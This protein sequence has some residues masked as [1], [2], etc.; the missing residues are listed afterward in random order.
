MTSVFSALFSHAAAPSP[1]LDHAPVREELFGI[2]RL[3]QH[4]YTLAAAQP[5][6]SKPPAV[7]SL[8]RRLNDNAKVL[9]AAYRASAAELANGRGV[10]P[11]AEWLLDNYHLVEEQIREI[12]DDLPPG[13]YRQLPKLASGP[14]AGYPR[15]LGMAWAF[16]AHTDSHFD[17]DILQRFIVAY[18]Q[19]QPLTIGELWAVAITLRIVLIENLRR[20]ADQMTAGRSARADADALASRLLGKDA[21]HAALDRELHERARTELS[22]PFAAQLAKRLR[23]HD[24]LTTP[25]LGWLEERLGAQGSSIDEVVQHAQQRQGASNLTVRNIINSMRLIS[26][27]DW[28]QLFE[29]VSLVDARLGA[30]SD[31]AAMDFATRNQYRSAIE[32]LAR[33]SRCSELEVAEQALL[34]TQQASATQNADPRTSDPGYHLIAEGRLALEQRIDFRPPLRLRISRGHM[35]LG[36][37]G[38]V[39]AIVGLA[40]LLLGLA[41]YSLAGQGVT[42][43]WL[44]A[45]GVLGFLPATEVATALVNRAVSSSFGAM[46]LPGLELSEGVP[47]SLRTLIAVPTLLGS[48]ADLLEQIERLEVHHLAGHGG[49]LTFALLTDGLD[50]QQEHLASDDALLQLASAAIDQLNQRY[51]PGT[52]GSRFLLLHRRR[53][54]NPS[55]N[56]W[57]GWER[58]RGK[59]HELNRLLRGA[60]DTSFTPVPGLSQRVP[61]AV[62]YVITLDADTRLPRDAA[63]RLIGKMAH[64]L[65]QPRFN[66]ELQRVV[67]GYAI[68]QPRVTPSLPL[69]REGSLYQ[70]VFS[71]PG[72]MDPYA[73]AVSDVYQDLFGEG[74]FTGKGI[75]DIDAFEAALAGRVRENS[76]L[77][78]DLFEGVFARAG[79]ASDVEVVEEFPSRYDVASKR[80]HRW[81]R[82]DWQLLPWIL[83]PVSGARALPNIGR[84]KMLD[85]LRRSLLAPAT[86]TALGLSWLLP[87]PAALSASLL[88]IASLLIPALLPLCFG[89]LPARAGIRWRSH[90]GKL[91]DDLL[92]ALLQSALNLTFLADQSWRMLDAISR[93]LTRLLITRRNLLEWTT[94]A[95]AAISPR[96]KLLGFYCGMAG[97][98]ALGLLLCALALFWSPTIWP[99]VL[100]FALLWLSAPAIAMLVSRSPRMAKRLLID[101]TQRNELR[102]IARRTWR[103]FETFVTPADNQLPPDNFQEDPK[104]VI[105]HRTSPTNMGLYLLSAIAA[106]DFGWAGTERTVTRLQA[107][108]A[109]MAQLQRHRG[110]FFNWYD[111]EDLR[112][113]APA[114]VSSVDSGN[115]AGHLLLVANACEEWLKA[116]VSADARQG[117]DDNVQL[118]RTALAALPTASS[119]RSQQLH[120][121]LQQIEAGLNGV[122]PLF[123]LLP[124]LLRLSDKATQLASGFATLDT[125]NQAGELLFWLQALTQALGDLQQDAELT[126][127]QRTT[128]HDALRS[129]AEQARNMALGMDFAFLLE[130]ERKLLSIGFCLADNSLDSSCYDL[131]ASE[132]RLA[133]LFAIAK[134]DVST[135]HWFRLGRTATP[136]GSGSALISWSG[137]MF[138]YLMPSLVMRAPAGSLLEQ[139][140]RLVVA[141]QAAYGN[142]LGIPWGISESAYNARDMEQTYQYSNFGVP[143]LGLKRG[144]SANRVIA[145][146]ATGLATMVD[147][148]GALANYRRLNE[149][150]ALGRYGFYE[151]L[152]FTRTRLPDEQPFAIVRNFMAHHQGMSIV[153]IAN[154][155]HDGQMRARFHRE[156]MIQAC[157]LL[158]QERMPRNVAVAH[159][160]AEEVSACATEADCTLHNERRLNHFNGN[161]PVTH[162]LS[163][164]RYSVMLTASGAGYSRWRDI[165]ITRW[166]EDSTR[167]SH[168]SFIFLWDTLNG[169]RWSLGAQP[170]SSNPY[171]EVVFAEDYASYSRH[172]GNLSTSLEVLVSGEDDGE[173]R[174]VSL[175]NSGRV[176]REIELTSYAELVL[177]S[178]ASDNAHPAFS[179]L[180][181]VTEYLPAFGALIATRRPRSASEPSLWAA[182]FAVIEGEVSAEPQYESDRAKF[183]GRSCALHAAAVIRQGQRL[184]NTVGT[185]LD[186]IFSLR[187]RLL[188]E[189]GKIARVAF[190]TVVAP[191]REALLDLIDKHHDRSAFERAKTLA[192]T[193]A[194]VQLRHLDMLAAEAADFQRLAAPILYA[195]SRFRA[196]PA[197]LLRGLGSQSGLWSQ[198]ISGD[199]PI[200]L[201]RISDAE[202]IAQVRQL[203]RAH[204]YWRMK[205][206]AV[207]LVIV[208]EH[209]SS[210]LQD[211]Q[212]AIET[213]VRSSQSRPR[214]T[215]EL[216]QGAVF[217]LRADLLSGE[218][219]ER[220]QAVARVLLVAH[221]GPIAEQLARIPACPSP[222]PASAS[223][224]SAQPLPVFHAA[225]PSPL[226]FANGQGGFDLDGREYVVRLDAW[227][228]TPAP[229][230]NVI[231]NP[232]FGFQVS[233]EGSGYTW[234]DNSRENQLTPWS[235]DPVSD[236]P[237]EALY[238]RD[239]DSLALFSPTAQPLRDSGHYEARHGFGYS[240]FSH[241]ASG[242]AMELL[243]FVPLD[244]PIKISR[245]TLRNL[246]GRPRRLSV[247]AYAEWV[248]GSTRAASAPFIVSQQDSATGAVMVRNPWSIAFTGR[249]AFSDL[250]GRQSSWTA[251]RSEF[252]GRNGNLTQPAALA[253]LAPLSGSLGAGLDPCT[254]L[255]CQLEL[256]PGESVEVLWFLGQCA[257]EQQAST[258]ITQYREADLDAVLLKVQAHWQRVLGAVQVQTPSRAMDIMLNGWLL[259]QT[260]ACRV[261]ARSAFYQASGA[262]G[263]RDQL[264]DGMA[265][266]FASPSITRGHILRAASRQFV[267]GDVQHWWLPH[268]GQ[269]VRTRI[270]DDRVW[271]AYATAQYIQ[272]SGDAAILD[273]QLDFLEGPLLTA[274][275][276]DAFFQPMQADAPA[277]LF[278][279]CARGLDQCLQ[280]TGE[281]GLPLIGGGDWNDGMNRVGEHGKGESVWLGWLLLRTIALFTPYAEAYDSARVARWRAH[282]EQL[283]LALET[284]AWDGQWYR[285]ATFDDGTWLGSV[286]SSECRI[287][288]IAQSWAVLSA[289]ADPLRANMAMAAMQ[290]QLIRE[291][292]GIALLF[293]PPFDKTPLEPGY[294]KGYPPGLRENG[295][296]YSHAAMWAILAYC[297]LGSAKQAF[298]LFDLVNPINHG[299]SPEACQRYKVEPYVLAADVYAVAPHNGRGGWT[300][301]TGAAGW[302]H[303]AGVEGILG[304]RREGDWLLLNPCIPPDWPGFS[305][306]I[307]LAGSHYQ[308]ELSNPAQRSQGIRQAWLDDQPIT[309]PQGPLKV[310]LD[311]AAHRL[312][313]E[314]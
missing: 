264:Q 7:L 284:Y 142:D 216:A 274:G 297:Q 220:L 134:G 227:S 89:L 161:P 54:F 298:D 178:A 51:G 28:A 81:T 194:Q 196:P 101:P 113:L 61:D 213:A 314:L 267:E 197:S 31:F 136:L 286:Q 312:R 276:H 36:M 23:D 109:V 137:S 189:P 309:C 26:S 164:G 170:S 222:V 87:L 77:S 278:E 65:N 127:S 143:G 42:A 281:L 152:D 290:R 306:R 186:P 159:P 124:A 292:D 80:Q 130:P 242:I 181:V 17:P 131:L 32:Q 208:N 153:A 76:L 133:S 296:Q 62:R 21:P 69:Q 119:E 207:D 13:Y 270:S 50:A 251:D 180:F 231:A 219:R 280:L 204:E 218:Y 294:I 24:P 250:G 158:L 203:L 245:L 99:L 155:L 193:Q 102:L 305:A 201:L 273:E 18:Q 20:L 191:T 185:V 234:A 58:K 114:Y 241:Q 209:A 228:N 190:W 215:A 165:A 56:V 43:G 265:L 15:V 9:L 313:I 125:D 128:L 29:N 116:P 34:A 198:G 243:Q 217:V 85:N 177:A 144:L 122:Q 5:I 105:A 67:G 169:T 283:R 3:E 117:I 301:Y 157:E 307:A 86:L 52:A 92:L 279:H 259:Y 224:H 173:V 149:M 100:P 111:T 60:T 19:V 225:P 289:S 311:G 73:A 162:L 115:L 255:Q 8:H 64:P 132:A 70:K 167:D 277:S 285:R 212:V 192:W 268:S 175:T 71:S 183:L 271:L 288:S 79:L 202:D 16:I 272:C 66:T 253:R 27:I 233:A 95:Q 168:G 63:L 97:G 121:L 308:I 123:S 226:E 282:A 147:P 55:E 287:D 249:S 171:D 49:D 300:W 310:A 240:R 145:P 141:R 247:T 244:D 238:I 98:T 35:H 12:R 223:N 146:Y 90:L 41:L 174:R 45:L 205:R 138:E 176:T 230:I 82:G 91:R 110:H 210:Y 214:F 14:F 258:L 94:A 37:P 11:A 156:P 48:E 166:Q 96:L 47:S 75:Y 163:N 107:T 118:A 239:E 160:R 154:T 126:D 78:H 150:G 256:Q 88:L 275:E 246:S 172:D 22:E 135:R 1:W 221:R 53:Q 269:G 108:L 261:W 229:W 33:G 293:T 211:L 235:N 232:Q 106:R 257:S 237:G 4:A 302:M 184:S 304:I 182:H 260:L 39:G 200:V 44:L 252:I 206:L 291:D 38:Y 59:L 40:S 139:T 248:L 84:W 187:Q 30:R 236:P 6:S 299:N 295:G 112:P 25:A 262:Y 179:K 74:S 104:P 188:I 2:E 195:D 57:M 72:G 68:L 140:N 103:F 83:G 120:E 151:A 10:V 266:T 148:Q 129:V 303:R 93:T 199:L 254:A 263:F 46:G